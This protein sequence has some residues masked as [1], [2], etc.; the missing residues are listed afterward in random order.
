[1]SIGR[2]LLDTYVKATAGIITA[3][4]VNW[5]FPAP[6]SNPSINM[7][8]IEAIGGILE[9]GIY[10]FFAQEIASFIS[11]RAAYG[12]DHA[13]DVAYL[14][15]LF[16]MPGAWAKIKNWYANIGFPQSGAFRG[17]IAAEESKIQEKAGETVQ[18]INHFIHKTEGELITLDDKY[19]GIKPCTDALCRNE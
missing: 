8:W 16:L 4:G 15:G 6:V 10:G 12:R 2:V 18:E 11:G 5:L 19:V 7:M 3:A 13:S 1:M 17:K 9:F 14:I